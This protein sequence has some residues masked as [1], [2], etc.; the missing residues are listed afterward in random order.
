MPSAV[1]AKRLARQR[2]KVVFATW[3]EVW[4]AKDFGRR[5]TLGLDPFERLAS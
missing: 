2:P 5:S 3:K 1:S 4:E